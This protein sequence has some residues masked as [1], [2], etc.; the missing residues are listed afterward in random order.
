M[1]RVLQPRYRFATEA[2][3]SA[4]HIVGADRTT[5]TARKRL[6]PFAPYGLPAKRLWDGIAHAPAITDEA[7]LLW[8]DE[9][10]NL[11]RLPFGH[12]HPRAVGAPVAFASAK[13]I[14][15]TPAILWIAAGD[16]TAQAFDGESLTRVVE[17][18]LDGAKVIDI[19]WDSYDSVYV[20][21]RAEGRIQLVHLHCSGKVERSLTPAEAIDASAIGF[22]GQ[23]NTLVLLAADRSRLYFIDARDGRLVRTV[24]VSTLRTCFDPSV[25]VTD[26]CAR[27]FLAGT[28][29]K[30]RGGGEQIVL[31]DDEGNLL[32]VA[33]TGER[34]TGMVAT[35]S[36]LFATTGKG[37][38]QFDPATTIPRGWGEV[39]MSAVT[40]ALRSPSRGPQQW[41]RVEASTA[42]PP[43]CSI[44]ISYAAA[45]DD[46]ARARAEAILKDD[47]L[48]HAQRLK[49]WHHEV[50]LHT[51]IYHG[52]PASAGQQITL[53][54]PLQDVHDEWIWIEIA[55]TAAPGGLVP[56]L[57]ELSVFYPG[58]TLVENLPA[59]YRRR[60]F[61]SNDFLRGL[62]GVLEAGTQDLDHKI[63]E[64]GRKIHPSTADGPWL[65]YV[66]SWLGLPWDNG[67]SIEQKRRLVGHS[68][69]VAAGYGTRTGL[70]A[71]LECLFPETPRRFR[72]IDTN[73][74]FGLA[75]LASPGG[76][77]SRLPAILGGLPSSAAVLGTRAILGK[78]CLPRNG[79][80]G[81]LSCLTGRVRV[82]I[83]ASAEDRRSSETWLQR[84]VDSMI[85]ATARADIR[86]L[87]RGTRGATRITDESKLR[88]QPEARLGTDAVTGRAQLGGRRRTRLPDRLTRK[89]KLQ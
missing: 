69:S 35:R 77:G 48:T 64:L 23:S 8:L 67:L 47:S 59:I 50:E 16:G 58:A 30:P 53:S 44:E 51:R 89:S 28:D 76:E 62:V 75:T 21:G 65:D 33:P 68:A 37:L 12:N 73:V 83:E 17:V 15:A 86:W 40:P 79:E 29:G 24:L 60:E 1:S 32:G 7:E 6:K 54:A 84:L 78:A 74:E 31:I 82:D 55:V 46:E 36:K 14:V 10:G 63:G 2:Q 57:S 11:L 71:L 9:G 22:L 52:S 27:I 13:R 5:S 38:L 81:D 43:G 87:G 56:S 70:E 3:W 85:P 20:L 80:D 18:R 88:A 34:V 72:I 26:G 25:L 39:R 66:A 4:C 45:A 41:M 19:A 42:L 61:E 49:R